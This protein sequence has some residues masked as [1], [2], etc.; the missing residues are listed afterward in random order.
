MGWN[1]K[2]DWNRKSDKINCKLKLDSEEDERYKRRR[3]VLTY[4]VLMISKTRQWDNV[5]LIILPV[6]SLHLLFIFVYLFLTLLLFHI[7]CAVLRIL[8]DYELIIARLYTF[9]MS[10]SMP[11]K[12]F[13]SNKNISVNF[14]TAFNFS[15]KRRFCRIQEH[16]GI[17]ETFF[18]PPVYL[19]W[20][21]Q[22]S[23]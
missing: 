22:L 21:L 1:E 18:F 23:Y 13:N 5:G 12:Q 15:H 3:C 16:T 9:F 20:A 17:L 11:G 19:Y 4:Q 2:M 6:I 7:W 8:S 10:V 14:M